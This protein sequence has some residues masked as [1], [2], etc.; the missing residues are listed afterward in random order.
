L[1]HAADV[2]VEVQ[3]AVGGRLGT[4]GEA[5]GRAGDVTGEAAVVRA[6]LAV[7]QVDFETEHGLGASDF[8]RE[9][10]TEAR[11]GIPLAIVVTPVVA[12]VEVS[13]GV[14]AWV[15]ETF[16]GTVGFGAL[17]GN[18]GTRNREAD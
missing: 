4:A 3:G 18:R 7:H 12:V 17:W 2:G 15:E 5:T 13:A 11:P 14:V 9:V 8:E 10:R 1:D 16:V 6:A